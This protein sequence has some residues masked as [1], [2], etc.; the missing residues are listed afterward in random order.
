MISIG[1]VGNHMHAVFP[2]NETIE[3]QRTIAA[4][5][6][7]ARMH[8]IA[9]ISLC[10]KVHGLTATLIAGT[11]QE[12]IPVSLEALIPHLYGCVASL[13]VAFFPL[14]ASLRI[15]DVTLIRRWPL[16]GAEVHVCGDDDSV[17]GMIDN[18]FV[19][20]R[21]HVIRCVAFQMQKQKI[22]FR[23]ANSLKAVGVVAG[24][25]RLGAF[26]VKRASVPVKVPET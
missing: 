18:D 17:H 6:G 21:Q 20:P 4:V 9:V 25:S 10:G 8:N 7:Q 15:A 22:K 14:H 2:G 5:V 13:R 16:S 24:D 23:R 3:P 26:G 12:Q 19:G 11:K 1:V